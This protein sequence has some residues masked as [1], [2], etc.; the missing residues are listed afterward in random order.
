LPVT[1]IPF[2]QVTDFGKIQRVSVAIEADLEQSRRERRKQPVIIEESGAG[3]N[4]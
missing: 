2:Q 4:L 3:Y 1:R